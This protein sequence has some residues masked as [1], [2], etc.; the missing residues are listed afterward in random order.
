MLGSLL[1]A[2]A[3]ASGAASHAHAPRVMPTPIFRSYGIPQGLPTA[4]VYTV[5]QDHT[6]YVWI[7]THAGLLRFDGRRFK[8][9]RHIPDRP[10]S[11]PGDDVSAVFVDRA[12][13]VWAGGGGS[14]LSL[15]DPATGGFRHWLHAANQPQ[16]LGSNDVMAIT[17][18]R[19]GALWVGTF[20]GGL[21]RLDAARTGFTHLRHVHGD[22]ASLVSNNVM[23]L[24]PGTHGGLWI[25]TAA[26]L[27]HMDASGHIRLVA[28]PVEPRQPTVWQINN[29]PDGVDAA[30]SGGLFHITAGGGITRIGKPGGVLASLRGRHGGIWIARRGGLT[31]IGAN[32]SV[33]RSVPETGLTG[34]L[35]GQFPDALFRDDEG[36]LWVA[37]LDGGL[38]YLPPQWQAY[39]LFRHRPGQADSLASDHV[40]VITLAPDGSLWVGGVHMLDRLDPTDGSVQHVPVPGLDKLSVIALAVDSSGRLWLGGHRGVHVWDGRHLRAAKPVGV[41]LTRGV[42]RLLATRDGAVYAAGVAKGLLR[43]HPDTMT[44]TPIKPPAPGEAARE[45]AQLGQ[46]PD[47]R[48]WVATHAGMARL[49]ADGKGLAFVPG[50]PTET[51]RGFGFGPRGGL[52]VAFSDRL[53]HYRLKDGKVTRIARVGAAQGWPGSALLGLQV[54][55]HGRVIALGARNL[56]V[57]DPR[58]HALRAYPIADGIA[59]PDFIGNQLLRAGPGELFAGSLNG[60]IGI[61]TGP[62]LQHIATPPVALESVSVVRNG[63]RVDLDPARPI[64]LNWRDRDLTVAA[65]VLSFINPARNQYRFRL[66]GFDAGW[67]DTGTRA[68]REFSVLEPGAY[69]LLISGRTGDGAW[70][71]PRAALSFRV[72]AAPWATPWAWAAY[73]VAVLLLVAWMLLAMRRRLHQRHRLALS[74]EHQRLAEQANAAKSRFLANMAHEIRTP[75]TGVLGMTELLLRTP[76]DERQQRYADAI[77]HSGS[78]LLR[79]VN[80]ALDVARIEAGRLELKAL[81]FDPAA[82]LRE[83]AEAETGLAAQKALALQ[84]AVAADVPRS[85]RGDALRVQQ[86]LFNLTHNALKFTARGGVTLK[87]ERTPDGIAYQVI[88]EGPGMTADECARVFE[89]FEQAEHGR[90]QRGSGLGLAISHDLVNLMGGS[91]GVHSIPGQGSTFT[92]RLPLAS[93]AADGGAPAAPAVA[94]ATPALP[95]PSPAAAGRQ[96]GATRRVLLVEDDPIAGPATAGIIETFG[97]AVALAPDALA[98]LSAMGTGAPFD[99]LV[100]DFD[101]P[102]MDGCELAKLLRGRGEA[103]P[104]IALTASARGDDEQRAHAAGM[105]AFLRKPATPA[106]LRAA[107]DDA[108]GRVHATGAGRPEPGQNADSAAQRHV[109]PDSADAPKTVA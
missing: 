55:R 67:V 60:V 76:L 65:R 77:R 31:R 62:L 26:G 27:D 93:V 85:V 73:V 44:L 108:C 94:T 58:D 5:T 92:L 20:A 12:G 103:I 68:V 109:N 64:T 89:R 80:D 51:V 95:A 106:E 99:A 43:V 8:V 35:P 78:L 1:L 11:L 66:R 13:H 17:Q 30:T 81:P 49:T 19:S 84:V 45:I 98:A 42:D 63:Q 61:R 24:A 75:L 53:V 54:D 23:S 72:L 69:H 6:G 87:L 102:G 82:V 48:L 38:A 33:T 22:P 29:T 4:T 47:G 52:W 90:L 36:G 14:G 41:I 25:G 107:L 83:V 34:S 74:E 50:I 57:Y 105:D 10:A 101:L 18:D 71:A 97:C 37:M 7:G 15:Y 56:R 79:Q 32:G 59:T 104:I 88:D 2:A 40:R 39:S 3:L 96:P 28:L 21:N 86:I 16:S 9:F 91:I 100:L 46:G 70:S